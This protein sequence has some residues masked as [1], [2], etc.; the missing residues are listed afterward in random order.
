MVFF[1]RV[2]IHPTEA[3][4]QEPWQC[5]TEKIRSPLRGRRD[6]LGSLIVLRYGENQ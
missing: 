2:P 3:C 4:Y 5:A 6:S 1:R